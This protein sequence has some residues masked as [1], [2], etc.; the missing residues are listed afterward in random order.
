MDTSR[1]RAEGT[2]RFSIA[3]T[4]RGAVEE[5]FRTFVEDPR[6]PC[7][8]GKGVVAAGNYSLEVYD[9]LGSAEST[10]HLAGDLAEF[11]VRRARR[12]SRF[13]TFVAVFP[14][15]APST[16]EEFERRLWMQLQALHD[17]DDPS[18]PWDP[19]VSDDPDD[20][21]FAFSF[22]GR[23]YFVVG[24]H[25]ESSRIAR[26]FPWPALVFNPHDQFETLRAAGHFDRLRQAIRRRDRALQ[27]SI[28]P[29][30]SDFGERSEAN[31][32]SGRRT[33]SGWKC[34]FHRKR[35]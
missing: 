12:P 24:L 1:V 6:F 16:E 7:L 15:S 25:P 31:Q 17:A 27:G 33:E 26:R 29:N 3:E 10:R 13:R 28:N 22:R 14:D 5:A 4:R 30:L 2:L 8:A 19:A 34:P 32:Y 9:S 21:R 11:P 18:V 35:S 23:A 20:P